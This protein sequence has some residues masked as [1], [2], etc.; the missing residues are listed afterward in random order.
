MELTPEERD[1]ILAEERARY[2]ARQQIEREAEQARAVEQARVDALRQLEHSETERQR[3]EAELRERT[4]PYCGVLNTLGV[5]V[6]RRCGRR[7]ANPEVVSN[8]QA[9]YV[10]PMKEQAPPPQWSDVSGPMKRKEFE[11]PVAPQL[12]TFI[13]GGTYF[14]YK[15]IWSHFFLYWLVF[16][17]TFGLSYFVYPFFAGGIIRKN[18]LKRG[19]RE[20]K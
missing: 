9:T 6:C 5:P 4:C 3:E 13:F 14:A 19:W 16:L 11:T 12:W 20:I 10:A 18:Y 2:E 7:F 17:C 8:S 1:K 15:G